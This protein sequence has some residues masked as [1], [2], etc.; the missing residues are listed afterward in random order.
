[1][2]CVDLKANRRDRLPLTRAAPNALDA[3]PPRHHYE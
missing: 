2:Y 1:M 3:Q